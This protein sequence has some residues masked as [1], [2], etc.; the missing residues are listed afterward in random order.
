MVKASDQYRSNHLIT[1]VAE[2]IF[3]DTFL[4]YPSREGLLT[5]PLAI[6]SGCRKTIKILRRSK[7]NYR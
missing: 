3:Y 5:V 1:L 6:G 4:N 7:N 2:K